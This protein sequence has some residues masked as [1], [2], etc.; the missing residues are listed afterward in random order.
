MISVGRLYF[1]E[2]TWVVKEPFDYDELDK[3]W[4]KSVEFY[5]FTKGIK[6][7]TGYLD[8]NGKP[9]KSKTIR[10]TDNYAWYLFLDH[11]VETIFEVRGD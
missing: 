10:G 1:F 9:V 5:D 4:D 6:Y 3:K 7:Y 2:N 8:S 11:E